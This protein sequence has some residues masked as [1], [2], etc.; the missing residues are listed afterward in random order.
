MA[1]GFTSPQ[2]G[3]VGGSGFTWFTFRG[4]VVAFAQALT[5]ASPAPVA[6]AAVVQPLNFRRPAEIVTPRAI[7][8]GTLTVTGWEVWNASVWHR[9]TGLAD[10]SD[11]ADVFQIMWNTG[12]N[13]LTASVVVDPP[14]G[15]GTG[16]KKYFRTYHGIK[17]TN[18]DDSEQID[19]TTMLLQKTVTFM[20]TYMTSQGGQ[21]PKKPKFPS[22]IS[23]SNG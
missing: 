12:N 1:D 2:H 5:I 13:D 16:G 8:A 4:S 14:V 10:A 11:L 23:T 7:G 9:L 22:E 20:Y 3:R 17:I 6:D 21:M 19:I 15:K 18:I